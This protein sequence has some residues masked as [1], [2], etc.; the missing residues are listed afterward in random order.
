VAVLKGKKAAERKRGSFE[1]Y[2]SELI[3]D[4]HDKK[5][6]LPDPTTL[7]CRRTDSDDLNSKT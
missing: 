5:E 4:F 3:I 1:I 2:S 6:E 7:Q